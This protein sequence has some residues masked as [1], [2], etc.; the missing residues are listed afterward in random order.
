G[1][2]LGRA[3][4]AS[5]RHPY[6]K[7]EGHLP[8]GAPPVT[9]D[10]RDQLVE[11]GVGERVVLHFADGTPAGHAQ[12]DRAAENPGLGKGRVEAAVGPEAVAQTRRR[13]ED[14][15]GAADVLADHHHRR[16][17]FELDVERVVDRLDDAQLS[18]AS[19]G[20]RRDRSRTTPADRRTRAP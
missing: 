7:R 6:D 12:A 16:V 15:A 14:A 5:V 18:Q 10:V 3:H 20:A 4:A 1:V 2:E 11:A 8:A 17:A 19:S 9:A 13:P